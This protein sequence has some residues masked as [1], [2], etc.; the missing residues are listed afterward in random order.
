MQTDNHAKRILLGISGGIAAYKAPM[1]V[2]NLRKMGADVVP[3]LTQNATR[4]VTETAL[5]AVADNRPRTDLWDADAEAAMGHIELARWADALIIAPATANV[6]ARLANGIADDLLTTLYLA[7]TAPVFVAPAMNVK[8]WEHAATGRN[9]ERLRDDGVTVLGPADGA[10]ACG[11]FGP[12]RMIEPDEIAEKVTAAIGTPRVLDGTRVLITAGPTREFLDPVRFISN[13]SSGRQ[14][15][16]LAEAAHN[17]GA[18]VT[19]VAGPV[20]LPTPTGIERIDVVSAKQMKDAVT[21]RAPHADI[22]VSV[23]AVADYRPHTVHGQKL[24]KSQQRSTDF[25]VALKEN[26]DIVGS[27][28]GVKPRPFV[29]GFAAETE[30]PLEHAREKRRRKCMDAIVVNDVSDPAIGFDSSDNAVTLIHAGGE[31]GLPKMRKG[32]IAR[33]LVDEIAALYASAGRG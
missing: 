10:Q 27:I 12:G 5:Q 33:R 22:F 6:I 11:E 26:E 14:G 2:R 19:L 4:F 31:V 8:M 25:R 28:A 13:R 32:A 9:L 7:T 17:A 1:L 21:C 23:A 30:S 3:V 18:Q 16:A 20:H 29:V 24:K 15:F